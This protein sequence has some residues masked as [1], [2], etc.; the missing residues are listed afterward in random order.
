MSKNIPPFFGCNMYE[1]ACVDNTTSELML[2]DAKDYGFDT[3]RFWCFYPTSTEKLEHLISCAKKYSLKLIPVLADRWNYNQKFEINSAWYNDGYKHKYLPYVLNLTERLKDCE[4]ILIWELINEPETKKFEYL[5]NFVSDVTKKIK[6][7]NSNHLI[8]IGTIGGIGDK[9]GSHFSRFYSTLFEKLYSIKGLD[10]VS[11][12]DYSYD[13]TLLDRI[14]IHFHFKGKAGAAKFFNMLNK[15]IVWI[16]G[17][18]DYFCLQNFNRIIS[19]P[20]SV[21][22]LWR[23][24][25]KKNIETA[26]SLNKQVYIGEIGYKSYNGNFRKNLIKHDRIRYFNEGVSGFLLW[27]FEAQGKSKDGQ[28]YGFGNN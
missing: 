2:R 26:M 7:T 3:V 13:A 9:F 21:R 11:I 10:I 27:S 24:Y 19:N 14:E 22:W 20:L 8:S 18:W 12:H 1:L 28:G 25:I 4:E 17:L 15:P 16:R 5:Y 6:E 23:H